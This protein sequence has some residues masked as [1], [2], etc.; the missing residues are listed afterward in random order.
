MKSPVLPSPFPS[1]ISSLLD[2]F[3]R[4]LTQLSLG[5][6]TRKL[7]LSDIARLLSHP[8]FSAVTLELLS[9][10]TN[11]LA[12]LNLPTIKSSHSLTRRS[13]ASIRQFGSFLATQY[14]L[15]NPTQN[16]SINPNPV[17]LTLPDSF[18]K[19][20]KTFCIYLKQEQLG[21][22]T[23]KSYKSDI[24]QYLTYH[25]THHTSSHI[26]ELLNEKNLQKYID[27][28]AQSLTQSPA[29][30]ERKIKTIRRFS[31][32][33]AT[34]VP[35]VVLSDNSQITAFT[36]GLPPESSTV[37][38]NS[39]YP[40]QHSTPHSIA[41]ILSPDQTLHSVKKNNYRKTWPTTFKKPT[42]RSLFTAAI[43][44]IL[45]STL[46]ILTY[47]QFGRDT[48]L[49]AAYPSTPVTPNRQL[50]FQGRLE[51]ASGT[52]IT[53]ATNFVFKLYDNSSGGTELYNSGTCS[54]TP[55]TDGVFSTQ[56][57]STC[58]AGI[59]SSVFT[60]NSNVYLDVTV[61][62]ETLTPRQ[63]IATVAYALNSETI[64][65]FPISATVS[66]IRNTVV[67]MNQW[68]E[69]IVGE[70]SPRLKGVAGTFQISA[71]ALSLIT[72]T[73]T[74]GNI[75]LAPDGTGQINATG[76]TTTTNFFNVSNAQLTSG[77]LITGTVANNNTGF[78]L[79]DLLSG[80][81]P[82]SKFSVSDAGNTTIAGTLTLPNTNTLTGVASYT[83]FSQGVSVGGATTYYINSSGTANLNAL[84]L[85]GTLDANG[86]VD[87]GDG[88]DTVTINGSS[89]T[90]T[91]FN[92]SGNTNGG[93]LTTNGSGVLQC[94]DDDGGGGGGDSYWRLSSGALSPV[95]DTLDLLIGSS[96]TSSAKFAF[97]N[98]NSGTPTLKF[99]QASAF[100][101][102]NSTVNSLS[103]ESGLLSFDTLNSRIGIGNTTPLATLDIAGS[104]SSSGTLT[105]RGTTDPKINILN[106]EN[107][108]L[109]FSPG[110]DAG[111]SEKFTVLSNGNVGIGVTNPSNKLEIAG[112]TST[113]SNSSGDLTI[114]SFSGN[115][116]FGTD[117][118]LIPT[119]GAGSADLGSSSAPWDNLYLS[120][121]AL[122]DNTASAFR[123][124]EGANTYLDITTTNDN[125]TFTLNLPVG[126]ATLHTA[127]LFNSNIAQ[128]INIGT[129]TAIDTINIGTGGTSADDINIGGLATSH[130]DLTGVMN[131]AGSTT[132]FVDATGNAKFLDLI[133]ADTA[134]PGLTV[135][136][137]SVGYAKIGGSTISDN[138]GNLTLDSD[139]AAI[140]FATDDTTL[141]ATGITT[142]DTA[143]SLLL[144]T[145][146][147]TLDSNS[148]INGGSGANDDLT[149]QGTSN[150]T[151]T[152]SYLLLQPT[153]GNVGIGT[154][155]PGKLL[156]VDGDIEISNSS[157]KLYDTFVTAGISLG[158]T[159]ETALTGFGA[160]SIV[161][162]LNELK[163]DDKYTSHNDYLSW[164]NHYQERAE[165]SDLT[166]SEALNGLFFDTFVD[167]TKID[168]TNS[169]S[170]GALRISDNEYRV[171]I[172]GGQTYNSSTTDNDGQTYLGSN[173]V[174]DM[175][176][177]DRSRDS[178]PE[179]LVELGIDPNWYNGVTL[180]VATSSA[181][182]SQAG[183]IADKN[184]NLTPTYN[185]SLIKAT[186]TDSTPRTIYIT[187]KSPT[188]FDWTNYQGDAATGV[189]ITPGT[190]QTLGATGVSVTFTG[191][192]NYNVGDVF[193]VASW[194]IEAESATRGAK[195][196][197]PEKANIVT[198]N[199]TSGVD[200]VD[201]DT[202]KLW[203][204]IDNASWKDSGSK[205]ASKLLNGN[206]YTSDAQG[207]RKLNFTTDIDQYYYGTSGLSQSN[208]NNSIASRNTAGSAIST[209][210]SSLSLVAAQANDIDAAVIPNQPTQEM[211]VSGWGYIAGNST[212][213]IGETVNLPYKF[214]ATP[215]INLTLSGYSNGSAPTSLSGCNATFGT[216]GVVPGT[217]AAAPTTNS[218]YSHFSLSSGAFG[219][220][221]YI[222][223]TWT[224]TGTVSPKQFVAVATGATSADGG[225]TIINETDGTKVDIGVG[226]LDAGFV[227]NQNKVAMVNNTIYTAN[228]DYTTNL[229]RLNVQ[230]GI[231]GFITD[232]TLHQY[233]NGSYRLGAQ[234]S[235]S[236]SGPTIL[237]TS[238]GTE[239]IKSLYATKHTSTNDPF[240][241]SIY[242]GTAAGL[243]VVQEKIGL[244]NKTDSL[245]EYS[246]SVKYYTKDYIS[247]EM[248]GDIRGMWPLSANAALSMSDASIKADTL[249]NNGTAT[250]VT[251]IRGVGV[252]LNG[253][254]QYLSCTDASCGGTSKLD[255]GS[256]NW[257]Y[258]AWIKTSSATRQAIISKGVGGDYSY[259]IDVAADG[260]II[261]DR[262]Q[263][264]G[265]A[266][267]QAPTTKTVADGQ[268]HHVVSVY[269]AATRLETYIDGQLA[270]SSTTTSGSDNT[271]SAA[272][273]EIGRRADGNFYFNGSI[274][275]PFVT[276]TALTGA[277]IKHMY[278]VGYRALQSHGTTLGGGAADTNQQ[279][280]GASNNIGVVA[281]DYNN[282]YMYVG[283][284]HT[285]DGALTKIQLNSDTAIKNW[286]V[287]DNDPD[288]GTQII[289]DDITSLAVG[290]QLEAVGSAASGVKSMAPDNNANGLTGS[291]FSKTQTL[292][293]ATKFAYL[294]T[295]VYTD[296]SD[297]A[298][299]I[300]VYGCNN[301]ATK[302][303][304]DSN[305]AW[306]LGT[307]IQTDTTQSPPE[308]EYNFAFSS[309]GSY[310][311][312]KIDFKR[313]DNKAN[314]YIERYGVS[315]SSSVG[316]ADIA[317]RYRSSEP[318]Y[319]GDIVAIDS[320]VEDG[321]ATV[322]KSSTP[323]DQKVIGVVTTNPGIVMDE[324]LVDLNWNASSRNSP[325]RPAVALA[326]R[327]PVKVSTRNGNI[328]VGD[329][330]TTSTIPGIGVRA[331]QSGTIVAKALE[332]FS[333]DTPSS[334]LMSDG[335]CEGKVL[336]F[337]NITH[338]E[339]SLY[340]SDLGDF[341]FAQDQDTATESGN[342]ASPFRLVRILADGSREVVDKIGTFG[343]VISESVKGKN[344]MIETISPLASGSAITVDAPVVIKPNSIA[345]D[346][347][348]LVVDGEIEATTISARTA[349]LDTLEVKNIIADRIT[350]NQIEGLEATI[351][352][353]SAG[354]NT[355]ISDT[356]L[357]SITD[358]IKSRL[359]S[360]T[361]PATAEDIPVPQE[362]PASQTPNE[363][364]GEVG[365]T[366]TSSASLV[367][368]DIDFAT[369]NTY[370]AVVGQATITTLDVTNGLYTDRIQSK[371]GLLALG[372]NALT[373]DS[374]GAVT[375]NGDLTI[376]GHLLADSASINNLQLGSPPTSSSSSALGQLLAVY[377][378]EGVA[379]ATIDAS[380]S[381]NLASLT[382][383]MITIASASTAT[384]SSALS[385]L[386]GTTQSNATAGSATL[387]T[388]NTE[389]TIES[390]HVT[391][392]TLV[393]LTPTTN[394]D[395]KVVFVKSK[396]SCTLSAAS[397]KPSFTIAIDSPAS[398]DISFNWWIIKLAQPSPSTL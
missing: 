150:A 387:T 280:A 296:S 346:L 167:S 165:G 50:S 44:L 109:Q 149:L 106:G 89:I 211:T 232:T 127:N 173:T 190:A 139:S 36:S 111:L 356:D 282:Q 43:L 32:W 57:G 6:V 68:G 12:Y 335:T 256:G 79:L 105:F 54:I 242:V 37:P 247:E 5:S 231:H 129:G 207:I 374:T 201:A 379:V 345:P 366:A 99:N 97:T 313:T 363:D 222:C 142:I 179:V 125:E 263:A 323:Y 188:T 24:T 293:S 354:T 202:Q 9:N 62:A 19:Y 223:Y 96:A 41:Q 262:I 29:T 300:N 73:G 152:T 376:N 95:N 39:V 239:Q 156:S 192:V 52:P 133:A 373:I 66:A 291:L 28:L 120:N 394:T 244:G 390:P 360:L 198:R 351:A 317:E 328:A 115:I 248:I 72:A 365:P 306:V 378:E 76:N 327:I 252:S 391:S 123:I 197:F 146:T 71:P 176:Y 253:S 322:K 236:T 15:S 31:H 163:S 143:A 177:Y 266:Y 94:S 319:P 128:T 278:Q 22:Q 290:Y 78:K 194:Y 273:F 269:T 25:Y 26:I 212:G 277:Q 85:A 350:A 67:P 180:S 325:D 46:S 4:Y 284:N 126:G 3:R 383:N 204:R 100:D 122:L 153:A 34:Q 385:S 108:G 174:N 114:D 240:S 218:F 312:F 364:G 58:G 92:C 164:A 353:L 330:I 134:N 141:T 102:Y 161:G 70:Q 219:A 393:Y 361:S 286:D 311:T 276:A 357:E 243:S 162:A 234:D 233:R 310:L 189:T 226:S 82:T 315:W 342:I 371:N 48:S 191:G 154:S 138:S 339:R 258:G 305:N 314:T 101:L 343:T 145:T 380:G 88:G 112:T 352:T 35:K 208:V 302:A 181:S 255:T 237:G 104:A 362:A 47:R 377:N 169:T 326:G 61:G 283:T 230:Y 203:M 49:T 186:G 358:R 63:Q 213:S 287:G 298:S 288:G 227:I 368:A 281:P 183:T 347:P 333:C 372:D 81:S 389:L 396:E 157:G 220:T 215:I 299:A 294:W 375:I 166:D 316:G 398:T 265:S 251:G 1:S 53:S 292:N 86:Q 392:D 103:I 45:T 168:A 171:G 344:L 307:L 178:S 279:L 65:G 199:G 42:L 217:D 60:E 158:A 195:Q 216:G 116:V 23:I 147:L 56:I 144:G 228:N 308:R 285:T 93:A 75:S 257:S 185:G 329:P 136:N 388:P 135:G 7:Y 83:Q 336:A 64:Q 274:D 295:N 334:T 249:T 140:T 395:N 132:Y 250:A 289:D 359:D 384:D 303:L 221:Q 246:G 241:S 206:L 259:E 2:D 209:I 117:D 121:I 20:I 275:E 355:Q 301:Y 110:G 338:Y 27:S 184:P 271:N 119:L 369:I 340:L 84:T 17:L 229:T 38:A 332:P 297:V 382:T 69:I 80:T 225:T 348:T 321:V 10:P 261:N 8:L 397:C 270:A 90:L 11:Y 304:C 205:T 341:V 214:N 331:N 16:L 367:S 172:T 59:A 254:S 349:V 77:S 324:N 337:A 245:I 118:D 318:V 224:A 40:A 320:P 187:I 18:N 370:L 130:V 107:F 21:E 309:T 91:G 124:I 235:W 260:T 381:A 210:N 113:I 151:R 200:I 13:L 74:N 160:S 98:I 196:Q 33:L 175:Y 170:S 193:K 14:G 131:F 30:I 272:A 137:G 268:W 55:D 264:G 159:N 51:N 155:T 148:T 182:Y 267:M 238:S 87:L 386:T